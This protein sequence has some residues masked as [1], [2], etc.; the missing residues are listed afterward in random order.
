MKKYRT[1]IY[2]GFSLMVLSAL[3]YSRDDS[4]LDSGWRFK[5]GEIAGAE[6]PQFDDHDWQ[7]VVLPHNWGWQEAQK[8]EDYY[9]GPG[10]YRRV[11]EL[12]QPKPGRR[13]FLRF[14]AAGSVADVYCNGILLGQHRGAFGAFCYEITKQLS[15]NGSNSIAVRAS[16]AP[17]K[18]VAPLSGDF[19]VFGG[20]YRPVHLIET[21]EI[22]FALTDH[23]S[24]GVAWHQTEVSKEE[25][26]V[27][28]AVEISNGSKL[29]R[30]FT[31][32]ALVYDA[33][34]KRVTT[35]EEP[36]TVVP[37]VT[38]PFDLQLVM[39]KP[40]LWNG[41]K[42]PYL[43]KAVVEIRSNEGV[44]VDAVE[45]PLGLRFYRVDPDKGFFLNGEPY[46]LHGVNRHQDKQ[47]KGTGDYRSR[48]ARGHQPGE[49]NRCDSDPLRPLSAQ[50]LFLQSVRH[51][52]DLCLGGASAGER[53]Q[54]IIAI[55]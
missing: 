54:P 10:W 28:V 33:S 37:E 50:R 52:R 35:V 7:P 29:V 17:E 48:Y 53:D 34:G 41:R 55:R 13:Y 43:Y 21:D 27:D 44:V 20:L 40:H 23:A 18:D 38:A 16:N 11:L 9:R 47:D 36:I 42:D 8:G 30:E 5:P 31:L 45:Q 49:R 2:T 3:L 25:A 51:G 19:D 22:C 39:P 15:P 14:E 24:P 46:H 26:V 4:R 32:V 1:L 12:A 6:Q